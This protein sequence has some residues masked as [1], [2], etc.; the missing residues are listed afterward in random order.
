MAHRRRQRRQLLLHLDVVG[1]RHHGGA[2][3]LRAR[4][5][6][7]YAERFSK[8][9]HRVPR[10]TA[11]RAVELVHAP[12]RGVLLEQRVKEP[13]VVEDALEDAATVD[14]V[15]VGAPAVKDVVVV[16]RHRVW[17]GRERVCK[18]RLAPVLGVHGEVEPLYLVRHLLRERVVEAAGLFRDAQ[19]LHHARKVPHV[20]VVQLVT[21]ANH[22][23][24]RTLLVAVHDVPP[25][26]LYATVLLLLVSLVKAVA[27]EEAPAPTL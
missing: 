26:R 12:R 18:Q 24:D 6:H 23:V 14:L 10:V 3:A 19:P 20:V 25:Q 4:I 13:R 7:A 15:R 27:A 8:A 1:R 11:K 2:A 9:R 5:Q 22:E 16:P 21:A 17:D